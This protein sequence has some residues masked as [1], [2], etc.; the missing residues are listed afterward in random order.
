M[1]ADTLWQQCSDKVCM[2][3]ELVLEILDM[4]YISQILYAQVPSGNIY[5]ACEFQGL[6]SIN[7]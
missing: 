3:L 2:L 5:T 1:K 4:I 7:R 6:C